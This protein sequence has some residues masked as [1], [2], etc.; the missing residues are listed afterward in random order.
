MARAIKKMLNSKVT[1]EKLYNNFELVN[2]FY[3]FGSDVQVFLNKVIK[4]FNAQG[5]GKT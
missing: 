5:K 1:D 3:F 4:V 2:S